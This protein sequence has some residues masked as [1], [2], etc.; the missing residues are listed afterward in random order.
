[1]TDHPC[2]LV[3]ERNMVIA[4]DVVEALREHAPRAI[5]VSA[6]SI[7]SAIRDISS[8]NH[9]TVAF[10]AAPAGAVQASGLGAAIEAR[11][12]QVVLCGTEVPEEGVELNGWRHLPRPFTSE[13]I[14]QAA[15]EAALAGG[16]RACA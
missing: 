9:L 5:V 14:Q 3:L 1:M 8:L 2:F 6:D 11:G 12:G 16:F 10:V 15:R 13:M 4:Q 7:V